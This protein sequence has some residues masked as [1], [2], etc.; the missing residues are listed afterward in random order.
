MKNMLFSTLALAA[1]SLNL[2]ATSGASAQSSPVSR[3]M[4]QDS[5][6]PVGDNQNSKSVGEWGG[7][8]LDDF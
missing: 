6:A 5:G 4:T 7:V 1:L 3:Q 2:V 8:M